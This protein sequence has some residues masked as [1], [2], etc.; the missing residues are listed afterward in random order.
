[1]GKVIET[2][3][4]IIS[5]YIFRRLILIFPTLIGIL[6]VNFIIIQASPGGPVDQAVA[7]IMGEGVAATA[8]IGGGG[9]SP[10]AGAGAPGGD[11]SYEFARGLDPELIAELE[12]QF[13]FDKPAHIRFFMMM[14]DYFSFEFGN[15]YYQDVPV[16]DLILERL[17]VSLSL[18]I[19]SLL[20][21]YSVSLPLGIRKAV[22]DGTPF[23]VWSSVVILVGYAVPA[24]VLAMLLII[25]FCGGEFF[26][27]FPLRGLISDNY[28]ELSMF[29]KIKDRIWHIAM[30]VTAMVAGSFAT[31]TMLTK[32][33]F[34]EEI[35]KQYVLTARAKGLAPKRVLYGHVFRNAMLIVIA[36]FPAALLGMLF[37][38]GVLIEVIF[39]L[40]GIGLLGFEAILTRDY[41]IVFATLFVFT[42]L[43][44]VTQLIADITYMLVDPRI[45]FEMREG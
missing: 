18:G 5:S 31:L 3:Q 12:R 10:S 14:R 13:G 42:L 39:S 29:D 40:R 24:F 27:W 45:D 26:N 41:P 23:D 34:L 2:T 11:S 38:G 32:N 43:G 9:G 17:P 30:P 44:L 22:T 6:L 19:A 20:I 7:R 8:Q 1:M 33:S 21:V 28:E 37:T 16:I 4:L 36:G 25:I 35:N 15:S